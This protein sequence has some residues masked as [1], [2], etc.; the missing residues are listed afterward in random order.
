MIQRLII[1]V[2]LMATASTLLGEEQK[3][4]KVSFNFRS[5]GWSFHAYP[6]GVIVGDYG[7]HAGRSIQLPPGTANFKEI[8]K[9]IKGSV[10]TV[11]KG[12]VRAAVRHAGEVSITLKP[13]DDKGYLRKLFL[14]HRTD[15]KNGRMPPSEEMLKFMER[16]EYYKK[17]NKAEKPTADCL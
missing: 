14:K 3:P 5:S 10:L 13:I 6:N 11:K 4:T 7:S 9:L 1:F 8:V 16:I 2:F 12:S 17:P 15:W